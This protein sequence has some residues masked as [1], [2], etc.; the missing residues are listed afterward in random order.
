MVNVIDNVLDIIYVIVG[1]AIVLVATLISN[2]SAER[3]KRIELIY[4]RQEDALAKLYEIANRE[5]KS[6]DELEKE[7]FSSMHGSIQSLYL[8]EKIVK[9]IYR[10]YLL[11]EQEK[12]RIH[13]KDRIERL[14]NAI[15]S[16][17]LGY[18]RGMEK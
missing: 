8:P 14:K 11:S 17:I 2:R 4:E 18:I 9:R 1:G 6:Y 5:Y 16:S 13:E 10:R 12:M 15:K 3:M 7:L